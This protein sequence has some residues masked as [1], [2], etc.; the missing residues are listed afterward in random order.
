M[1]DNN[2]RL[3]NINKVSDGATTAMKTSDTLSDNAT[4]ISEEDEA[5]AEK[6]AELELE[7]AV[8][9]KKRD[10]QGV[11]KKLEEYFE[12]YLPQVL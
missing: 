8:L 7:A 9:H 1:S 3:Q 10:W 5:I 12:V 11:D 6:C 2:Q 4:R